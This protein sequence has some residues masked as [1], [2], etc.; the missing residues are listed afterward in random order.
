[1]TL[2][3]MTPRERFNAI[4]GNKKP[5][6]MPIRLMFNSACGVMYGM[7]FREVFSSP[8]NYAK[9]QI[10]AYKRYGY[11]N[12][13]ASYVGH[14]IGVALGA[15][16]TWPENSHSFISEFPIQS[17]ADLSCLDLDKTTLEK[18]ITAQQSFEVCEILLSALG[19]E[20]EVGIAFPGPGTAAASLVGTET[21]LRWTTRFPEQA[22]KLLEFSMLAVKNISLPFLRLGIVPSISDPVA[23]GAIMGKRRYEE[24]IFPYTKQI[25]SYW[26]EYG[27]QIYGYHVC[28]DTTAVLPMMAESGTGDI[29]LDNRVSLLTASE[30]VGNVVALSGNIDPVSIIRDGSSTEIDS[31]IAKA[32]KDCRNNPKGFTLS[33]GC[34][35]PIGTPLEKLDT[36][37][38]TAKYYAAKYAC[39]EDDA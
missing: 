15:K 6:R 27:D 17:P 11:D 20:V 18:D 22:K 16:L 31:A 34:G 38:E 37:M 29:S 13:N 25:F 19:D 30:T 4:R 36:F 33:S 12:V 10:A 26:K 23:T 39:T 24:F 1:M 21:F 35:I 2:D 3:E 32:Y 28:G 8:R 9:C 7:T 14:S 5:D